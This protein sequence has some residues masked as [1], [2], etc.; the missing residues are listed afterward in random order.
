[1]DMVALGHDRPRRARHVPP[2]VERTAELCR[3]SDIGAKSR[4]ALGS[5]AKHS[6]R[7][8]RAYEEAIAAGFD[9]ERQLVEGHFPLV[10]RLVS[11][12]ASGLYSVR[13][14]RDDLLQ[15]GLAAFLRACRRFDPGRGTKLSTFVAYYI[16]EAVRDAYTAS[17]DFSGAYGGDLAVALRPY[18]LWLEEDLGRHPRPEEIAA[19]WNDAVVTRYSA[20]VTSTP[21]WKDASSAE[22]RTEA[23]RRVRSRGLLL[24]PEWVS[25][26]LRRNESMV[27]IDPQLDETGAAFGSVAH[28]SAEEE[29]LERIDEEHARTLQAERLEAVGKALEELLP[30]IER[31]VVVLLFG[32]GGARP[33]TQDQVAKH[34]G[35]RDGRGVAGVLASAL[36]RLAGSELLQQLAG[37][38]DDG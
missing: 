21:G 33:M 4:I 38:A 28:P 30:L 17:S 12:S 6:E 15:V 8:R 32:L 25:Q 14:E 26:I 11:I 29:A 16:K 27:R 2:S 10:A 23:E 22:I 35:I 34:F 36:S 18:V 31:Q 3:L 7:A 9:A 1:M 20:G 24:N 13:V 5:S 37:G 19:A